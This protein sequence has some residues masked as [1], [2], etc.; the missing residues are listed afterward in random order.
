MDK[1]NRNEISKLQR[2][3]QDITRENQDQAY[4]IN[5]K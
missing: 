3:I 2:D 4:E 5:V 1:R